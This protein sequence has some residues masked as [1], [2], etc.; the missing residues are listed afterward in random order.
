MSSPHCNAF[1]GLTKDVFD[2]LAWSSLIAGCATKDCGVYQ[3]LFRDKAKEL[4]GGGF[5]ELARAARALQSVAALYIRIDQPRQ[6]F[7][8]LRP[9]PGFQLP[10]PDDFGEPLL[11]VFAEMARCPDDLEFQARLADLCWSTQKKR[12]FS[13]VA[14]A[15]EAYLASAANFCRHV[16]EEKEIDR[17]RRWDAAC[18]RLKRALRLATMTK[19]KLLKKVQAAYEHVFTNSLTKAPFLELGSLLTSYQN[20]FEGDRGW[21]IKISDQCAIRA[22]EEKQWEHQRHFLRLKA[23]WQRKAEEGDLAISTEEQRAESYLHDANENP[24]FHG[25]ARWVAKARKAYLETSPKSPRMEALKKMMDDYQRQGMAEM[26]T[27]TIPLGHG[28][29][30][31]LIAKHLSGQPFPEAIRR[32][33]MIHPPLNEKDVNQ[34]VLQRCKD[35][36][37]ALAGQDLIDWDGRI[38]A[39][40]GSVMSDD[41]EVRE[42]AVRAEMFRAALDFQKAVTAGFIEP[43]RMQLL[44]EHNATFQ[45]FYHVIV[46]SP[47][48]PPGREYFF[49]RG[50]YEGLNGD[51]LLAAHLLIPQ[52]EHALRFHLEQRGV[53]VT[54][55]SNEGVQELMDINKLFG[56][57]REKLLELFGAEQVFELEGLLVRRYGANL[58][59]SFAHGL[60]WPDQFYD[61][62]VIY[63]WWVTLR[64]CLAHFSSIP[65]TQPS[66]VPPG[67]EATKDSPSPENH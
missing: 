66:P 59:N 21:L 2:K 60:F 18:V 65:Q 7:Q 16:K 14:P 32:L 11:M 49:V 56:W 63:L 37:Y 45:D 44:S 53:D 3:D 62:S 23:N 41:P 4:E 67:T 30:P 42:H 38:I 24:T 64:L 31:L 39:R 40:R 50:L 61:S 22:E 20:A 6:P 43:A 52:L 33:A 12:D 27:V 13:L 28:I 9:M 58:R 57:R 5:P 34:T 8:C 25:K 10:G 54:T 19:H 36:W 17:C 55:L 51:F 29:D 48:V 1:D 15:I 47:F 46:D 26:E 35:P